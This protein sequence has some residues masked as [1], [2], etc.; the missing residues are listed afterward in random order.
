MNDTWIAELI[1]ALMIPTVGY[2]LAYVLEKILRRFTK[3]VTFMEL[4]GRMIHLRVPLMAST[5]EIWQKIDEYY[6]QEKASSEGRG[7]T[8]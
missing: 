3:E 8:V 6:A 4:S 7:R 1:L 5:R 2:P